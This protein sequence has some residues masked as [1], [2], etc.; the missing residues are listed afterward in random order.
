MRTMT[1]DYVKSK[2][3][4]TNSFVESAIQAYNAKY[5]DDK[6][7]VRNGT[8]RPRKKEKQ[9]ALDRFSLK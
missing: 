4:E 9:R 7:L 3:K 1:I 2:A 6:K 8:R 5:G